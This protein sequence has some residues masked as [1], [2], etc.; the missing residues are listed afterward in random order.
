MGRKSKKGAEPEKVKPVCFYCLRS[1]ENEDVLY[2]HQKLIH[3]RCP[4]CG[5]KF[6]SAPNMAIHMKTIHQL[7]LKSV[8]KAEPDRDDPTLNVM[9]SVGVPTEAERIESNRKRARPTDAIDSLVDSVAASLAEQNS[10]SANVAPPPPGK[11]M[12]YEDELVSPEEKRSM[13]PKYRFDEAS[14][15]EKLSAM[16][17]SIEARLTAMRNRIKAGTS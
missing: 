4:D 7:D 14:L 3:F 12:V 6:G 11:G 2:S 10:S 9:G 16:D 15:R 13:L 5:K 8:P 1:F 17:Q